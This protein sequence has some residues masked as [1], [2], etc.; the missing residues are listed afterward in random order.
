MVTRMRVVMAK[1]AV[2][3]MAK[4]AGTQQQEDGYWHLAR[5]EQQHTVPGGTP[6]CEHL[7]WAWHTVL[8]PVGRSDKDQEQKI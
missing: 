3:A 2:A 4:V 1:T 8:G 5:Q 7:C 6:G